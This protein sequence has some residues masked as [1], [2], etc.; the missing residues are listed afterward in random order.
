MVDGLAVAHEWTEGVGD[1]GEGFFGDV[2]PLARLHE[3]FPIVRMREPMNVIA[4][5]QYAGTL[6]LAAVA[7]VRR[8][9]QTCADAF[10]EVRAVGIA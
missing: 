1:H 2:S 4:F 9:V 6:L 3:L 8:G 10:N 7:D 5:P